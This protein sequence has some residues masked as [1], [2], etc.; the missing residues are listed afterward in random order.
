MNPKNLVRWLKRTPA[1]LMV[2]L[3][4]ACLRFILREGVGVVQADELNLPKNAVAARFL[5]DVA[6]ARTLLLEHLQPT[7]GPVKVAVLLPPSAVHFDYLELPEGLDA[8]ELEYQVVRQIT[9]SLGLLLSDVYY[10]WTVLPS[11]G[12]SFTQTVLL[13]LAR[14]LEVAQ[15]EALFSGS[16]YKI[17]HVCAEPLIW[18]Q[19]FAKKEGSSYA[20]CHVTHDAMH[21]Y[22]FNDL[23]QVQLFHRRFDAEQMGEQN[24]EHVPAQFVVDGIEHALHQVLTDSKLKQLHA[25]HVFGSGV[26]WPAVVDSLQSKLRMPVHVVQVAELAELDQKASYGALWELGQ[27]MVEGVR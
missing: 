23:K 17:S 24:S 4:G 21:L 6:L 7:Q 26:S 13:V 5:T 27:Q 14:Q 10:D 20:V 22:W 2:Q 18:A 15:Y 3:D 9:Q 8:D 19:A 1:Q 11:I 16:H 12:S 25:L